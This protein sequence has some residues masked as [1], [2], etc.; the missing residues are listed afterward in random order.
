MAKNSTTERQDEYLSFIR[1]F[2]KENGYPPTLDE[3]A[4]KMKV[5]VG[6]V[7]SVL[8]AL[9]TKG[10]VKWKKGQYRTLTVVN[11]GR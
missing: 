10:L 8:A 11:K 1:D 4:A 6:S 2:T 5:K 7:Q 9:Q 3:L